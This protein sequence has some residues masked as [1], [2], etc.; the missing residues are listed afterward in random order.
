MCE[1]NDGQMDGRTNGFGDECNLKAVSTEM[2]QC[3]RYKYIR[4]K[5]S[6]GII[7][8]GR[9]MFESPK[10][11]IHSRVNLSLCR[12][13]KIVFAKCPCPKLKFARI[14]IRK[15]WRFEKTPPQQIKKHK[16]I[17]GCRGTFKHCR[18]QIKKILI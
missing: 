18:F 10:T 15:A 12:F 2:V 16:F 1:H 11:Q 3:K 8:Q 9:N 6:Q 17:F 7:C 4:S 13:L 5:M 14:G